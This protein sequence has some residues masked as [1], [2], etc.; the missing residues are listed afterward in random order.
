MRG[1][2]WA[3]E[4]GFQR[5]AMLWTTMGPA[6]SH[7]YV[8][9]LVVLIGALI[10]LSNLRFKEDETV[11]VPVLCFLTVYLLGGYVS[12]IA[13]ESVGFETVQVGRSR[14]GG[15]YE[16][17]PTRS[18]SGSERW[19]RAT[20]YSGMDLFGFI[21]VGL[22]HL[23]LLLPKVQ[24]KLAHKQTKE[25]RDVHQSP[26]DRSVITEFERFKLVAGGLCALVLFVALYQTLQKP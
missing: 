19:H 3:L 18:V 12:F 14:D 4:A 7:G 6:S 22:V 2:P 5:S 16:T 8:C 9:F 1:N 21:G 20:R 11:G 10:C 15:E 24:A 23:W 25:V 17:T 13:G 26:W